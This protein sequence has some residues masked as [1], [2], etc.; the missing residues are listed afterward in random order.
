VVSTGTITSVKEEEEKLSTSIELN[1]SMAM[2]PE[3]SYN[4]KIK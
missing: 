2:E 3:V 4:V 1:R